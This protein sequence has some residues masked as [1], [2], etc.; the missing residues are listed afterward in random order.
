LPQNYFLPG[1]KLCESFHFFPK[2]NFHIV[3]LVIFTTKNVATVGGQVLDY[4]LMDVFDPLKQT[5]AFG[6]LSAVMGRR[7]A[8]DSIFEVI[9]KLAE[10]SIQ[11]IKKT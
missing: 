3:F 2:L 5:T 8:S 10:L 11:V 1:L 9:M 6:L 4:V 7:L